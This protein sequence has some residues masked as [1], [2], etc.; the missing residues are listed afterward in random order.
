MGF[1]VLERIAKTDALVSRRQPELSVTF[2]S[3]R[4]WPRANSTQATCKGRA[5][6]SR[7][8]RRL[9]GNPRSRLPP[10]TYPTRLA[11]SRALRP[12]VRERTE[13]AV[14][15]RLYPRAFVDD[16]LNSVQTALREGST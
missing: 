13:E 3:T 9:G 12:A 8:A 7:R 6:S 11:Q 5:R 10:L 16:F 1:Y 14:R 15:D 2:A 4:R